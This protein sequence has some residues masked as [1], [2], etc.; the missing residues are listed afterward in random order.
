[1][2]AAPFRLLHET[3]HPLRQWTP[4]VAG[5]L[6]GI[7]TTWLLIPG[8]APPTLSFLGLWMLA[9]RCTIPVFFFS[10]IGVWA[11]A[12]A[13]E[14]HPTRARI[15]ETIDVACL[16]TW[17]PPLAIFFR[18]RSWLAALIAAAIAVTV[19]RAAVVRSSPAEPNRTL[20]PA[21]CIG[22]LL[23]TAALAI[24]IDDRPSCAIALAAASCLIVW[25]LTAKNVWPRRPARLKRFRI[26]PALILGISFSAGGLGSHLARGKDSGSGPGGGL[27]NLLLGGASQQTANASGN[28][29]GAVVIGESYPGVILWPDTEKHVTLV[30]P[31]PAASH[32]LFAGKAIDSLSIPFYG[33]Y[34]FFKAPGPQPKNF[35]VTHG[36]PTAMSFRSTDLGPLAMEARQN[37]ASLIDV[38]CCSSIAVIVRNG[39]HRPDVI[40]LALELVLRNTSL[41]DKPSTTLGPEPV[42]LAPHDKPL[43]ESSIVF[44]MRP[45]LPIRQFDEVTVRFLHSWPGAD[46][47][48]RIAVR[49]F[50]FNRGS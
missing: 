20:F 32:T 15:D 42:P 47:S 45:G 21:I 12:S 17:L 3:A 43:T 14:T 23:Q 24:I 34:W 35:F 13:L 1:M 7:V 2:G 5:L 33:A 4:S 38:S 39:D 25:I 36:D 37:F 10:A 16:A 26:V 22:L 9:T 48:V 41:A 40:N 11:T 29:T 30:P 50:I 19:T 31:L 6:A 8:L 28:N 27:L 46:R 49:R 18:N 44:P